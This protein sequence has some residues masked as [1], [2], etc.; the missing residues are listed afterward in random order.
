MRLFRRD[1]AYLK[2]FEPCYDER[3]DDSDS[4]NMK[5][6]RRNRTMIL[7]VLLL[8]L[9]VAIVFHFVMKGHVATQPMPVVQIESNDRNNN[10]ETVPLINTYWRLVTLNAKPV[11]VYNAEAHFVLESGTGRFH[12]SSGCN[13]IMGE[14]K[15]DPK[16]LTFST[17]VA[18]TRM[19]CAEGAKQEAAFLT[20]LQEVRS[21]GIS[22]DNLMLLNDQGRMIARFKQQL[23]Q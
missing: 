10:S 20:A 12:G 22:E 15:S 13:R 2:G 6:K 19:I 21:W 18:T 8:L 11:K 14:Y 7:I 5:T 17:P 23:M 16:A 4:K 1:Y 3:M 9:L